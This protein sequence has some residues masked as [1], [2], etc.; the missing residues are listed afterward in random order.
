[1]N[2]R[3]QG[4]EKSLREKLGPIIKWIKEEGGVRDSKVKKALKSVG[5][6]MNTLT[7]YYPIYEE[8]RT[9]PNGRTYTYICVADIGDRVVSVDHR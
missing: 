1:M 8:E 6:G 3:K 5:S 7:F 2:Y 4:L 9:G